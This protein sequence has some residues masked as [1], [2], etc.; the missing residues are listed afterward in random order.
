M[1]RCFLN[2][3]VLISP[4]LIERSLLPA[5]SYAGPNGYGYVGV[6]YLHAGPNGFW[7]VVLLVWLAGS[8]G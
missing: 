1:L 3:S 2:Y 4:F 8:N 6:P 7:G 5:F